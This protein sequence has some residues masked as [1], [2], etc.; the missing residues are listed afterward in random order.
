M[1]IVEDNDQFY[2]VKSVFQDKV[3]GPFETKEEAERYLS[4]YRHANFLIDNGV[5]E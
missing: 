5:S 4:C 2:I 1:L 3:I